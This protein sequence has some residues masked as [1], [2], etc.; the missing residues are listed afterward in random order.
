[1]RKFLI[2]FLAV[3]VLFS[4]CTGEKTV[5]SGDKVS[6]DYIG[7]LQNG[8][9]FDTS[10]ESVA[11]QNNIYMPDRQYKPLQFTVGKG[12]VIKGFDEGVVG[13]NAGETKTLTIPP[14]KG[15]GNM[16]PRAIQTIPVV[17]NITATET[18]PKVLEVP[19]Y[20]FEGTFGQNHTT[21]DVVTWPRTNV[22][23][24]VVNISSNNISLSY[25]LKVG[26]NI[27][28]VGAPW[29]DTVIKMDDKN[30]TIKHDVRT[31]NT[32]QL[33]GVPWN[34]TVIAAN[35]ENITLRHNAVPDTE[36]RSMF[37]EVVRVHFNQTSIVLDRNPELAGKTLIFNV[38][39]RSINGSNN[40]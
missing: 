3:I 9:V 28:S 20:Q 7:S 4:G 32:I 8:T 1:M 33:Q 15:Y 37:G 6:V 38:T 29:N 18:Y 5:K 34:S 22:N 36:I 19:R 2:L 12:E 30:F 21:G 17:E 14:E 11:K 23:L 24:T 39:L 13:M 27:S 25:N 26:D 35:S 10:I 16:D 40:K 31:N